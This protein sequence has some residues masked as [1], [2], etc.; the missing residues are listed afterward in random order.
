MSRF[1]SWLPTR[2]DRRVRVF[3]WLSLIAQIVLIGTGG[4]VRLT[5]SGLGCPTW[6]AC[7]AD[8]LVN[9]P[10]MGI[11]GVIEFGNRLMT[12][13]L[14]FIAI[15]MF[16]LVI[17]MRA[18]RRDLFLLSLLIGLGIPAQGVIGGLSVLTGLNPYVVGLHFVVSIALVCLATALVN[19]VYSAPG[20]R[21]LATPRWYA[22]LAHVASAV[23]AVT[24][25][26]GIITTGSGPHAGDADAPRNGLDPQVL[27][28]VHSWPAYATLALTVVLLI[29]VLVAKIPGG[30]PVLL[31]LGVEAVQIVVGL[32]QA[33]TGLPPFLV[34]LHMVLAGCLAAAM[35]NVVLS[36]RRPSAATLSAPEHRDARVSA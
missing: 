17:R 32:I 35:T 26:V 34:G 11:H 22:T 19:R 5:A 18:E 36:L 25:V 27:Q 28:H 21:V 7:T 30:G 13:V 9:T 23:V 4:L 14:V 3:A 16:L 12:F 33:R 2:I 10:E 8:S 31:L 29:A 15:A 20:A 1:I 24:I 6:P